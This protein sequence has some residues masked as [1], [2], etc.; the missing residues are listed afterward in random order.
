M[1]FKT[2]KS[3]CV[4]T[5]AKGIATCAKPLYSGVSKLKKMEKPSTEGIMDKLKSF[6]EVEGFAGKSI[7]FLKE[8]KVY[9][10]GSA[11]GVALA[12]TGVI[13][14][15][16]ATA[17][18]TPVAE[19]TGAPTTASVEAEKP[20]SIM[21]AGVEV[22][23]LKD[24]D[25]I[26]DMSIP[27]Y[28]LVANNRRIGF[29]RNR[30]EALDVL[31][32][33]KNIYLNQLEGSKVLECYFKEITD[34]QTGYTRIAD[35][36]GFKSKELAVN[37]IIKG[38][39]EDTFH[40]VA[41]GENFWT[42]ATKYGI[43]V[44]SLVAANPSIKPERIQIG[45]KISLT[46]PKPLVTVV[47]VEEAEY[48]ESIDY[49]VEY[50][51]DS[52]IYKGESKT[53]T[54]GASGERDVVAK[55]VKSNGIEKDRVIVS[56]KVTKEPVTKI[57][58][59]GTKNPPPKKGTG[60]F[61]RP[62]SRGVV[63]SGFGWRWGKRHE[64]IDIGLPIGSEVKAADGGVVI[65]SGTKSGY[66][67]VIIIDHGANKTSLYAHNSKLLVSKGDKVFKG[68]QIAK[69]GNTGYSTGPHLHF[70]IRINGVPTN[71]TKYVNY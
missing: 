50:T 24:V 26:M 58:A 70:E 43:S 27:G 33:L 11:A 39:T 30:S 31:N 59:K 62:T 6:S 42:I 61:A 20:A 55:I 36:D 48:T 66:G 53:T 13:A 2:M 56:E 65:F 37:Y 22:D 1:D 8:N 40:E 46:V 68:Q 18:T 28:E 15:S 35:F 7:T 9:A 45:Q 3:K 19:V 38:T 63:T 44:D 32:E 12:L 67:K 14:L 60:T 23:Y 29:F 21:L 54:K 25:M 57:V 69:S 52:S 34:V 17:N 5:L 71:P 4:D 16:G 47:T 41:Q 10:I 51:E 49:A 64:G